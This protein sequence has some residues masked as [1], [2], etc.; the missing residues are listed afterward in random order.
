ME[1]LGGLIHRMP[2]TAL[3][4]PGRLRR[5]LGPAAAQRLRLR[6][7]DFPGDPA[8]PGTAAMGAEA[9]GAG[10]RRAA[11]AVG[12]ARRRV[13]RRG[14][15]HRLPRP[16]AHRRRRSAR[17][18]VDRCSLAAMFG[19][20]RAVRARAGILPGFVIDAL[21]PVVQRLVGGRMPV[22]TG[23]AVAVDRAGRRRPQL[24][25]RPARLPLHR[26]LGDRSRPSPSIASPR[27]R[28]RRGAGLGLRLPRPEPGDAIHR[29]QLRP[30][31]PPGLRHARVPCARAGRHAGARRAAAGALRRSSCTISIWDGLYA[32][33][34]ARRRHRRRPAQS[35]AVP[36]HPPLSRL[37]F[38]ALVVLLLVL[39]LWRVIASI[40]PS[41][42]RRCCWCC[43][44]RR[45][46]PASSARSRRGCCAGGARRCCSPTATCCG[47]CARRWC[48][49]TTPPGCSAST[50]YLIFAATW[51]AAALVPTFAT[52]LM[53]SWSADLIAII[54][55][56]GSARF[57]L[58]LAGLDVG[59]SFG[60]IG[61]EPRGD[62]RLARRAGDA[63]DRLHARADRRLDAAL[64]R[65]PTSCR[66]RHVGPAR[67]ARR[68][69]WS[70]W[71]SSRSP[72]TPASRSTTRR[73]ISSSPW[74]TRRWC[75]NIPAGTW[76]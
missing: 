19:A 15:R 17:A 38:V 54:A 43:C 25:Q 21:A 55:L 51:V 58:A 75:W 42:A 70:R 20:G 34:A 56:L 3:R 46:S 33:I 26:G 44:W 65:S 57:F 52:G 28:V 31:D 36:D 62:D 37:V 9:A 35:S 16:A 8:E 66:R 48:S 12:G 41:R 49:P 71:S 72:R 14:V 2:L 32:P 69:R 59:T 61:V 68:W 76:R 1:Q 45:C 13:L 30:A 29:R 73:R 22:Q 50:P 47:C 40:S 18:E 24:L 64:D 39:A 4:V 67:L 11:G 5:D 23:I 53:F 6:M 74:C 7:A 27:A 10:D 60:G 63:D